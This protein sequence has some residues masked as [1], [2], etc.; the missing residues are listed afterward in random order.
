MNTS[1]LH[2][3][4][5]DRKDSEMRAALNSGWSRFDLWW[6]RAQETGNEC[7]FSGDAAGAAK[8]WRRAGWIARTMFAANDPRR[9]TSRANLALVDQKAGRARRARDGYARACTLWQHAD[10]FIAGMNIARRARSSLFHLRMEALH[11]D[12]YQDNMRK[13]YT[14]IA[15]EVA[16]ALRALEHGQPAT[17][18]LY[19]RWRGEKPALFDDT[20]KFLGAALLV[21]SDRHTLPDI[22][23]EDVS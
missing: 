20:R 5:S 19:E 3:L 11:W 21:G 6:E 4:V 16:H 12:T 9:A 18:R 14:A 13:R 7:H 1:A 15:G 17:C 8:A 10:D 23:P 2:I 22:E